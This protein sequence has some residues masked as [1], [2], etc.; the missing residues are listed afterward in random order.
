M[1]NCYMT[2]LYDELTLLLR[3]DMSGKLCQVSY[4]DML[5]VN[6]LKF[7]VL[8]PMNLLSIRNNY[9]VVFPFFVDFWFVELVN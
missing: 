2:Q 4:F 5:I 3:I 8:I 1:L 9:L 6:K 7:I